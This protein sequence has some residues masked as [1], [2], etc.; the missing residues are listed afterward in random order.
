MIYL[1]L[2]VLTTVVALFNG[3]ENIITWKIYVN[4]SKI[5]IQTKKYFKAFV[6]GVY[7][8]TC[9]MKI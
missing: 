2:T 7:V 3:F 1:D 6:L 8:E 4:N 9:I 5:P